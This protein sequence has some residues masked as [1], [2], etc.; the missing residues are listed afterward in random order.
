MPEPSDPTASRRTFGEL[1]CLK[2]RCDEGG[3]ER[4][5]LLRCLRRRTLPFALFIPLFYPGSLHRERVLIKDLWRC[6]TEAEV[7]EAI[8]Y[9][10]G[11]RSRG[12]PF[13]TARLS[14]SRLKKLARRIFATTP[15][16]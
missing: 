14:S 2:Y 10:Q 6:R 7:E 13:W 9:Y 5:I 11:L 15:T 16:G 8:S 12:E 3:F 4:R 1:F